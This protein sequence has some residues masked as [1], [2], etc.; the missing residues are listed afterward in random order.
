MKKLN[1]LLFVVAFVV[2]VITACGG[3]PSPTP[4]PEEPTPTAA[5]VA[6]TPLPPTPAP[7]AP[8]NALLRLLRFVPDTPEYREYLTYGDAEAWHASWDIPRIDSWDELE[9]LDREPAA[10][11]MFIMPRQTTPPDTLGYEY[12]HSEDQRGFYGFDLFNLDRFLSAG[13]PPDRI[14]VVEFS[15][16]EAPVADA[17]TA[18]GYET[19]ELE[20]GGTLYSILD[21][22]E[23][24][25]DFPTRSGSLGNLN[26][27]AL[28]D[29]QMVIAKATDPVTNALLAQSGDLPSLAD[30]AEYVAAV[31]A[32]E[33]PAL[34]EPGELVGVILM[35]GSNLADASGYL[36]GAPE[37]AVAQLE[38]YAEGPPL[39][40]YNLVAFA[41]R[42]S[43]GASYLILAVVFPEGMDADSAADI[44]ADRLKN[45]ISL[46]TGGPLDERWTFDMATGIEAGGLPVALVAMRVDDP[47]PTPEDQTM[48]NTAVLPWIDLVIRHDTL[49]L[50]TGLPEE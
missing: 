17:L 27:I 20:T 19:E 4:A 9:A 5:P 30:S 31:T 50:V 41:T 25:L 49:F 37:E 43:E 12:L 35:E 39:P 18:S 2:V 46:T 6:P 26:R 11:W 45:Y 28:L 48:V 1:L 10:Y 13:N 38:E 34:A 47:P 15:F 24:A 32:L 40:A 7:P 16:D 44:L 23:V 22:Y 33:D 8:G 21:D 29:G 42:H 3:G 36:R 14:T